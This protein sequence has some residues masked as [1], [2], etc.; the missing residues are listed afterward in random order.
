MQG[1]AYSTVC[2]AH[3]NFPETRENWKY[4]WSG[5]T[6]SVGHEMTIGLTARNTPSGAVDHRKSL[7][8]DFT[9]PR[10]TKLGTP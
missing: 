5:E 6:V 4:S 7:R 8:V 1:P 3:D 10:E 9:L 2:A